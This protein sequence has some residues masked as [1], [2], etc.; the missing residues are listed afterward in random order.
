MGTPMARYQR[1]RSGG[2][3]AAPVTANWI[4]SSPTRPRTLANAT[5]SR[6]AQVASSSAVAVPAVRRS[7]MGTAVA[8]ASSKRALASGSAASALDAGVELL[9]HPGHP[10]HGLGV[11][12]AGVGGD[13]RGVGRVVTSNPATQAR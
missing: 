10:E 11:D 7:T 6:N 1:I 13:L 9:P 8:T 12:V 2:M 5:S 3:G 4:A